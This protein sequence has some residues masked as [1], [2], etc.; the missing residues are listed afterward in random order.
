MG[1]RASVVNANYADLDKVLEA[2]GYKEVN[3]V[4]LDLGMSSYQLERSSRGFSFLRDEPLDMRMDRVG[5]MTAHH[6]I[7]TLSLKDLSDI[8]KRYGEEKKARL[9]ARA[10]VKAREKAPVETSLELASIVK[11]VFPKDYRFK[12]I[13]PAT[14]VFQAL[15]IEVNRELANLETF[16]GKIPSLI[17]KGGRLVILSYHSLEDRLVKQAMSDW[18]RTCTCP[19]DFPQCVCGKSALFKKL[20]KKGLVPGREEVLD[21]PRARSARLRAAERI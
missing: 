19:T 9:I 15:R 11:S 7:N 17:A 4:L 18:E 2:L 10:I 1:D 21:N 6:L 16:L 3:G 20:L 8:F 5:G 12:T 14:R 13:H